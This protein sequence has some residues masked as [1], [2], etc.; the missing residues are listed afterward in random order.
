MYMKNILISFLMSAVLF[1]VSYSIDNG[2]EL[3]G[4]KSYPIPNK[5]VAS[6]GPINISAEEFYYSYRYGPAFAKRESN[7]KSIY[8]KYMIY[9]KLLA[10][11]G[12][13]KNFDKRKDIASIIKEFGNDIATG[14]MFK[15]D[16]L[17]KVKISQAEIDTLIVQKQLQLN[18]KWLYAKDK[19]KLNIIL[20]EMKGGLSFDSL[21]S[22]QFKDSIYTNDRSLKTNRYQLGLKNS[23]FARII[24][25]LHIGSPSKPIKETDGW[26]II[27]LDNV[28]KNVFMDKTEFTKLRYESIEALKKKKMDKLSDRY[29]NKILLRNKPVIKR[30]SF[31][32]LRSYIAMKS[33]PKKK[34]DDWRL[35]EKLKAALN[36]LKV[37]KKNISKTVLVTLKGGSVDLGKFLD[38]FWNR[39]QYIKLDNSNLRSFSVTL[40]N[41]IWRMVRDKLLSERAYARKYNR[42]KEYIKQVKWWKD[43]IVY[44]AERNAIE[45]SV[46]L[47]DKEV[48]IN[49]KDSTKIKLN[50][51]KQKIKITRMF[52]L[53]LN[54]LKSKYR[55]KINKDVL[56]KIHVSDEQDPKAIEFYIVKK[57]GLIPRPAYPSIDPWWANW[58]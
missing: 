24:D 10:L 9:E 48:I 32:L 34:Y 25:T 22:M 4:S 36:S 18:I 55:V 57:D 56:E 29:V 40:E 27:K 17:K 13:A 52:F 47:Q 38:W 42:T 31:N 39:S 50:K 46:L 5:V 20:K 3:Q 19:N 2:L 7:S 44:S 16:I 15:D 53:K 35:S 6:V 12:Y 43:K 23:A 8:L 58:E 51:E 37:T 49:K 45:K 41:L 33:L 54:K 11:E 1:N 30:N 26:Y 14:E 21:Y 28:F